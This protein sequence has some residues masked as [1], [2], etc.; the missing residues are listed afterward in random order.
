MSYRADDMQMIY[1]QPILIGTKWEGLAVLV[2]VYEPEE[3]YYFTLQT[4]A[5]IQT[6]I[7]RGLR[8]VGLGMIVGDFRLIDERPDD[9]HAAI[10]WKDYR[11]R[12][13][14]SREPAEEILRMLIG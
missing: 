7:E 10:A 12:K 13:S 5:Y 8:I 14:K 11:P 3:T 9:V 6:A 4:A 1:Y 2:W